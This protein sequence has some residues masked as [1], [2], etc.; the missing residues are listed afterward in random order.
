MPWYR[1]RHL[2]R[3]LSSPIL[4]PMIS[5]AGW[6]KRTIGYI[7]IRKN[8]LQSKQTLLSLTIHISISRRV[9]NAKP[10]DGQGQPAEA[11]FLYHILTLKRA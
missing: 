7:Y 6:K 5:A 9:K 8:Y 1:A 11:L 2:E 3:P 4:N 10:G